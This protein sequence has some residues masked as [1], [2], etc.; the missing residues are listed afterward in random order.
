[1]YSHHPAPRHKL[2]EVPKAR[3]RLCVLLTLAATTAACDID[4]QCKGTT[5]CWNGECEEYVGQ[6]TN[7]INA[8]AKECIEELRL[9]YSTFYL[10]QVDVHTH[11]ETS[12][13]GHCVIAYDTHGETD[14]VDIDTYFQKTRDNIRR[15]DD[16][17][18]LC[19][20][21]KT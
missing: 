21:S 14:G 12:I 5:T 19:E 1:M 2:S 4:Y 20:R 10:M 6:R 8:C 18:A 11:H 13:P 15:L 17:Y 16:G 9:Y 3:L 7:A